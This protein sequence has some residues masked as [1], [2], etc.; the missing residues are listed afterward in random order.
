M[1]KNLIILVLTEDDARALSKLGKVIGR[2]APPG[3]WVL[4]SPALGV[5]AKEATKSLDEEIAGLRTAEAAAASRGDYKTADQRKEDVAKVESNR[6][7]TIRNAW[8]GAQ[9]A[10]RKKRMEVFIEPLLRGANP[11]N[12]VRAWPIQSTPEHVEPKDW[13]S[14]LQEVKG[15]FPKWALEWGSFSIHSASSLLAIAEALS[16]STTNQDP[17]TELVQQQGEKTTP[18]PA[19]KV[20]PEKISAAPLTREQE[21]Q[22]MP[23]FTLKSV[24]MK[25][26]IEVPKGRK[27]KEIIADVLAAETS[28]AA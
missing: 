4:Y 27:A 3:M 26:G 2:L 18:A 25:L 22:K 6:S 10:E 1:N 19:E 20:S 5:D 12:E 28:V 11:K 16:G 13:L 7:V 9:P 14:G 23:F 15:H 21:L 24:A 17:V 8:K